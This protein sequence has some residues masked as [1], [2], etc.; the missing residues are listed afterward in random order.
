MV[1]GY[2]AAETHFRQNWIHSICIYQTHWKTGYLIIQHQ[3]GPHRTEHSCQIPRMTSRQEPHIQGACKR[4]N[5]KSNGQH[6]HKYQ[7]IQ[8]ICTKLALNKS[9]Y[10]SSTKAL[11][12]LHWLPIQQQ[13]QY[14]IL[15]LIFKCIHNTAPVYLQELVTIKQ[16]ARENMRSN[17]LNTTQNI[18]S[19]KGNIC[20]QGILILSTN[21]MEQITKAHQRSHIIGSIQD[22]T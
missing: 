1:D 9:K 3:W 2:N 20:C 21:I 18:K 4:K 5:Q 16:N 7:T 22:H 8:N 6:L 15:T 12:T 13:I 19:Q 11:K 17:L 14:K 10:S